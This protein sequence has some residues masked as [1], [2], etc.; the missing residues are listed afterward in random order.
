MCSSIVSWGQTSD[1]DT[2]L[3]K[4]QQTYDSTRAL[5]A[6]FSQVATLSSLNRQQT[7][8]G[9]VYIEKPHSI[10][11]E[12]KTPDPQT[13][14]YDGTTLRIYTPKRR[15]MLQSQ[16]DESNRGNVAFLFL[17]GIGKLRETF[18]VK[19]LASSEPHL[20]SLLLTPRSSQ[21]GFSELHITVSTQSFLVEKLLIHD[22]IGNLTEI[23]LSGLGSHA[24]LPPQTFDLTIP[25]ETEILTPT[26]FTGRK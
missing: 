11:W 24:M 19:A 7:S 23:R 10:R 26:D 16:V 20:A 1:L 4:I 6:D 14:L 2:L 8:T 22:N 17:A 9:R 3:D 18:D 12:Y 13:I 5:T 15:Q 21:A 25:P